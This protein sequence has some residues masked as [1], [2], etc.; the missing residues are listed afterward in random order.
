VNLRFYVRYPDGDGWKRG[1][2]FIKEIVPR[3]AIT[4]I[5]NALYNENYMTLPMRH[6]W[7]DRAGLKYIE[8]GWKTAGKWDHISVQARSQAQPIAIG[9][10]EEFISEHYWG[11][12]QIN[13]TKTSAYQ[14]EHPRWE[15][16]PVEKYDIRVNAEKLYGKA[17]V[18]FLSQ[19]PLSVFLAEGS[20]IIVRQG[21]KLN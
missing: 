12:T 7:E 13:S 8:Y 6:R 3:R 16:Y 5:A 19:P 15:V 18:P 11:Y 2:A 20:E 17:F 1:V 4:W 10:E 9:S 14:V 21:E